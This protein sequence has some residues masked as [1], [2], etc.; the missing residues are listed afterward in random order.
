MELT[1][2]QIEFLRGFK[3]NVDDDN[4]KYKQIIKET[5]INNNMILYLLN[6]K[7]LEEQ[8]AD[9][10][11]YLDTNILDYYLIHPTQFD[12][13]N[14]I[15]FE[16]ETRELDRYNSNMKKLNII[17]YILCE[18]KNIKE[19]TTGIARHD[20]IAAVIK[21]IFNWDNHFAVKFTASQIYQVLLIMTT[22]VVLLFSNNI[23]ITI[24]QRQDLE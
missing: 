1:K 2:E 19:K 16:I 11:D 10:S 5:L 13:Q 4:I 3:R 6:N 17:F 9:A 20:L 22:H 24:S 18:E 23:L 7:K 15:C 8:E 14:F 21:D 12:V